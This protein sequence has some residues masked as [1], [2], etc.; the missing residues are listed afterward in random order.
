MRGIIG[1]YH[2]Y[3]FDNF[4]KR[5]ECKQASLIRCWHRKAGFLSDDWP[6]SREITGTPITE[7]AGVK[8]YILV[9]GDSE[10]AFGTSDV[11]TIQPV[12]DAELKWRGQSP[13]VLNEARFRPCIF[14]IS[15]ELK[16]FT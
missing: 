5:A 9:L 14:D 6:P 1:V 11:I 7:P 16:R 13:A 3:G 15:R 8:P 10:F 2:F 12:I 4:S